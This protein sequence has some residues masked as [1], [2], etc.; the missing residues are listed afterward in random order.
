MVSQNDWTW[1]TIFN[2]LK[3][4]ALTEK[5]PQMSVQDVQDR[6]AQFITTLASK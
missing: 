2:R 4:A 5:A 1:V 6:S 3:T